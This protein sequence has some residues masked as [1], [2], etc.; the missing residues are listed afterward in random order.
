MGA[1]DTNNVECSL[2]SFST[3]PSSDAYVRFSTSV[4]LV[5]LGV[6]INAI[7][8]I[9]GTVRQGWENPFTTASGHAYGVD[10][11]AVS[12]A[13]ASIANRL[14]DCHVAPGL[15][16]VVCVDVLK[17]K[18]CVAVVH[19]LLRR[20]ENGSCYITK[21][22]PNDI[23]RNNDICNDSLSPFS[24]GRSEFMGQIVDTGDHP[25]NIAYYYDRETLAREEVFTSV[26]D[27]LE[28]SAVCFNQYACNA[29]YAS[30]ITSKLV[31]VV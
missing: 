28:S 5:L 27:G 10:M 4:S 22:P 18:I 20:E 31:L 1:Q 21:S 11:V 17:G 3:L 15:I 14:Q 25:F 13:I 19:L 16:E 9:Y 30:S 12:T 24:N 2:S 29:S 8:F 7:K 23:L 26:L 6:Y